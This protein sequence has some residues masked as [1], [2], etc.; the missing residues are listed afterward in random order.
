MTV[1][2]YVRRLRKAVG[3]E[4]LWLPSV[5]AVVVNDAG[6]LLLGKRADDGRWSV[7]S[8]V[9][10]PDEQPAQALVR[11]VHEE[12]GVRVAPVRVSSVLARPHTYPNGDQCQ[13]LNIGFRCRFLDGVARVND[14]ESV[15]V[16]WFSPDRLPPVDEH[17]QITIA[18]A[19]APAGTATWFAADASA[20]A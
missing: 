9:V 13:F 14:D 2:E 17:A 12:T 16:G 1:P 15:A 18:Q 19:L 4:L 7:I 3:H 20:F 8:G 6:E 5:S 11:E 10:E